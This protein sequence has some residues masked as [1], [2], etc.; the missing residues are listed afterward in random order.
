[1]D[2][3]QSFSDIE[4]RGKKTTRKEIFLNAMEEFIPWAEWL[5]LIEP[6]YPKARN[7]RPPIDMEVM[8]R[9]YLVQNWFNLSDEARKT[10]LRLKEYTPTCGISYRFYGGAA[11]ALPEASKL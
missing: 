7:G 2:K 4:Y 5:A 9:M 3:Q 10:H 8:F 11:G 6:H 1:M